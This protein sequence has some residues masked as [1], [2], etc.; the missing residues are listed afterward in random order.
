MIH[1]RGK[2]SSPWGKQFQVVIDWN[3]YRNSEPWPHEDRIPR[4]Y[5]DIDGMS[6][7]CFA[8]DDYDMT[9]IRELKVELLRA[10]TD[11]IEKIVRLYASMT[12][13][14]EAEKIRIQDS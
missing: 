8:P 7:G 10:W 9:A 6:V 14:L 2:I 5:V 12:T 11:K 3:E 4:R 13:L 1:I